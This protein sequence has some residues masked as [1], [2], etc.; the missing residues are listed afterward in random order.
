[1]KARLVQTGPE[2]AGMLARLHGMCFHREA[3]WDEAAFASL[4]ATPGMTALVAAVP[5]GEAGESV[6]AG[7]ILYRLAADEGEIITLATLPAMRRRGLGGRLLGAAL[8]EMAM[9]G[10]R[11]AFLEVA[12]GNAPAIALYEKHGFSRAG[13]R[14]RYYAAPHGGREDALVMALAFGEGC[15][16]DV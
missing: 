15:G 5:A 7:L 2:G 12:A 8:A 6:P 4:L 14:K 10:A 16:C 9:S 1:M 3:A 11:R 13:L